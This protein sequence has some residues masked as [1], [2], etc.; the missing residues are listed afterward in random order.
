MNR[1]ER[2]KLRQKAAQAGP[3]TRKFFKKLNKNRNLDPEHVLYEL[4]EEAFATYDCLECANCCRSISPIIYEKDIDRIARYLKM[5]PSKVTEKYF[6]KDEEGDFVFRSKTC[7]YYKERL[8]ARA[9][10]WTSEG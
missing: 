10:K 1:Q 5:K 9:S 4:H 7:F 3:A 6:Q 2:E 8:E